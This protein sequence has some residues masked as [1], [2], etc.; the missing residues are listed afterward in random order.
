MHLLTGEVPFA[1]TELFRSRLPSG[2]LWLICSL[3][4]SGLYWLEFPG[5]AVFSVSADGSVIAGRASG[6][7]GPAIIEHLFINQVQPL[8]ASL[9]GRFLLHGGAVN[10]NGAAV[11]FVGPSGAGKSS[12]TASFAAAGSEYLSD[13]SFELRPAVGG[14]DVVPGH[15]SI[16]LF[17]DAEKTI[18]ADFA[19]KGTEPTRSVKR[20]IHGH[21]KL[22]HCSQTLPLACLFLL[23]Q[24]DPSSECTLRRSMPGVAI[25]S[26]LSQSFLLNVRDKIMMSRH[27]DF[28]STLIR[29][30]L[31]FDLHYPRDFKRL[32]EVRGLVAKHVE[33]LSSEAI[34][35]AA[36]TR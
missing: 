29:R 13:D 26:L 19:A 34:A 27:L 3:D 18:L 21:D 16:R 1:L 22:T 15:N 36:Q 23:Q 28:L 35:E 5:S 31:V 17:P 12:M 32:D 20:R 25:P 9:Q 24:R 2:E 11:A 7:H 10:L 33:N 8:A 30:N 4:A 14:F 6:A